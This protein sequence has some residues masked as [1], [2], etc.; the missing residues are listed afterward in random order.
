[1][2]TEQAILLEYRETGDLQ[3]LGALYEPYMPVV[4]GLCI[5]YLKDEARSEDAVMEIFEELI[6]KL[7]IHQVSNFKSWLYTVARNHCLLQ[8]R[9]AGRMEMV[10]IEEQFVEI[11]DFLYP[12]D[13][14]V[15]REEQLSLMES[16]LQTLN[17]EQQRCVRLFYLEQKCYKEVVELTG[18]E[19]NKVKSY[20]QNG[21]RNLKICMEKSIE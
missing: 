3:L 9:A 8:V 11:D 20:I 2:R 4:Y 13:T 17:E 15:G 14:T 18:F 5:K 19:I 12:N 21:K 10:S 1:M 7:R 16:C 6:S